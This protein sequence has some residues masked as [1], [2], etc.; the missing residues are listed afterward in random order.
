MV[1]HV[2]KLSGTILHCAV[3]AQPRRGG[4]QDV[5]NKVGHRRGII[6]KPVATK[7]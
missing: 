5:R 7:L 1:Q 4:G 6:E 2:T 3:F